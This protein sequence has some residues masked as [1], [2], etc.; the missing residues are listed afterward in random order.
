MLRDSLVPGGELSVLLL[1][2]VVDLLAEAG[3]ASAD[4]AGIVA[5]AGPGSFTGIRIGLAV[6]K[7]MAE[8]LG[9][10]VVTVSRLQL[11]SSIAGTPT[12]VLDAH[13]GQMYCGMFGENSQEI[14][15]TAGEVNAM[16]GLPGPVGVCEEAVAQ[17][18][19]ELVGEPAIVRVNAPSA[20]DVLR[21]GLSDWLAGEF[22]DVAALDGYY[23]RGADAKLAVGRA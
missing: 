23:L 4:I 17:T 9:I 7:G 16:G 19:E 15:L 12:A 1:Q 3:L 22:A 21:F 5:V 8:A 2:A 11:L 6:V 18:L 14:L 10:P 20:G 13:R